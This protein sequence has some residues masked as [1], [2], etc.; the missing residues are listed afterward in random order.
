MEKI[1][2]VFQWIAANFQQDKLL[3]DKAGNIIAFV[4]SIL[5]FVFWNNLVWCALIGW[6]IATICGII[7]DYLFD[8]YV[9]KETPDKWDVIATSFGG[10]EVCLIE[11]LI[12]ILI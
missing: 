2:A 12:F 10:F 6:G 7:K 9:V 11:L 4:V 8:K 1:L 3:H 5:S